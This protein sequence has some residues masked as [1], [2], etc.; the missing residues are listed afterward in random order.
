MIMFTML[1]EC[2]VLYVTSHQVSLSIKQQYE[3]TWLLH[4]LFNKTQNTVH[5]LPSQL[6]TKTHN[7]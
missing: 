1:M 4:S 6:K 2:H 7:E 5:S 3:L